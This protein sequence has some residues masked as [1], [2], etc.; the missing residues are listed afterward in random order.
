MQAE[1]TRA[2]ID[3][4]RSEINSLVGHVMRNQSEYRMLKGK[5]PNA[6]FLPVGLVKRLSRAYKQV[7]VE[8]GAQ[9]CGMEVVESDD[10]ELG[11]VFTK[12][13]Q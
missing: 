10:F 11:T 4:L 8:S 12:S 1:L 2:E 13:N 3:G 9:F 7:S 6:V 5:S